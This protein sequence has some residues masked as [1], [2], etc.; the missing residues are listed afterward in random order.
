[1]EVDA[2]A[3][4]NDK[5]NPFPAICSIC[6]QDSLCFRCLGPFDVETHMIDGEQR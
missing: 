1:M 5:K 2:V 3:T 4:Q 6:M